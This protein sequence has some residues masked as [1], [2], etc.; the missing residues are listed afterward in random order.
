MLILG[1]LPMGRS[2]WALPDYYGN[3]AT[4]IGFLRSLVEEDG[5]RVIGACSVSAMV[6]AHYSR[7]FV[8]K[9]RSRHAIEAHG[10]VRKGE[11]L[12]QYVERPRTRP[13]A[14]TILDRIQA[15]YL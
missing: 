13:P 3:A 4:C 8:A 1:V 10:I 14:W 11:Y 9:S 2:C 5:C 12:E 6:L 7:R 15:Y